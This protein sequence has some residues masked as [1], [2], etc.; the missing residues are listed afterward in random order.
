MPVLFSPLLLGIFIKLYD[1][2]VD[3]K[4]LDDPT[5]IHTLQSCIITF[6]TMIGYQDFYISF[7]Y[8]IIGI[9]CTGMDHPFWKSGQ[10]VLFGLF[11][12]TI[13]FADHAT[14]Y[15]IGVT[16]SVLLSFMYGQYV[17]HLHFPEEYS[18][19]KWASRVIFVFILFASLW[20]MGY[21]PLDESMLRIKKGLYFLLGYNLTSIIVQLYHLIKTMDMYEC[22]RIIQCEIWNNSGK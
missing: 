18:W 11:L 22:I 13:P 3:M 19:K 2:I 9:F 7:T 6:I 20:I 17:E 15:G 8:F 10:Y 16:L 5:V 14:L 21:F 4:L 1:D 12:I